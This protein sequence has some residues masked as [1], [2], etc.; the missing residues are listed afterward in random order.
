MTA[1]VTI[2][3][4]KGVKQVAHAVYDFAKDG[5]A[6]GAGNEINLFDLSANTIV[7]DFW[8]EVETAP[9]SLGLATVEV[10]VTGGDT[11]SVLAQA[12][13]AI[14][15]IDTVTSD[16]MKGVALWD[17]AEDSNLRYKVTAATT[18]SMLIGTA[19][20]TAGKIHFYCEYSAGY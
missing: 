6:F 2:N 9:T 12:A 14:L 5:G 7:H 16:V 20:L 19:A 11:D 1:K 18:L 3:G 13:I 10:G 15:A 4:L 8:A 17:T